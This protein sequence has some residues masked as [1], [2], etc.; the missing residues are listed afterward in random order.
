MARLAGYHSATDALAW[1]P[2]DDKDNMLLEATYTRS[3]EARM[4][5]PAS[6]EHN[7]HRVSDGTVVVLSEM[8][9]M[10]EGA[11]CVR[12]RRALQAQ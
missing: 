4:G 2:Y 11:G 1:V 10:T 9:S 7:R 12:V 5:L 6:G 8:K 3:K